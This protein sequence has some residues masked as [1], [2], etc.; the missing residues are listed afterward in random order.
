MSPTKLKIISLVSVFFFMILMYDTAFGDVVRSGSLQARSNGTNV[1]IT[2]VT[3]DES[4][5]AR[6]E[7]ERRSGAEGDFGYIATVNTKGA[8]IYEF[9]DYSSYRSTGTL[10]QYRLKVVYSD[11]RTATYAGPV[12]VIHTVSGVRRTWGS[13]KAMFR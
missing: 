4:S 12:S 5:V 1:T 11:G 9:V 7:V 2:W 8:S 10:Y 6:F 3:D 13:I